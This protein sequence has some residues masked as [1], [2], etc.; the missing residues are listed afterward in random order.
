MALIVPLSVIAVVVAVIIGARFTCCGVDGVV[1]GVT[2]G[3]PHP[4]NA[5]AKAIPGAT[6]PN[7][8]NLKTKSSQAAS[9]PDGRKIT[10]RR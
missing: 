10:E 3:L 4:A 6:A 9:K 2:E 7:R 8:P 1:D 5:T